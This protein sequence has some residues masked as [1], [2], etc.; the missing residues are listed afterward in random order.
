M[1]HENTTL[2]PLDGAKDQNKVFDKM[3][4]IP[5]LNAVIRIKQGWAGS[6]LPAVVKLQSPSCIHIWESCLLL[7]VLPMPPG[8]FTIAGGPDKL[9]NLV[10]SL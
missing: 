10:I 5:A 7:S 8:T 6:V 4:A 2:W 1:N 3:N 9:F